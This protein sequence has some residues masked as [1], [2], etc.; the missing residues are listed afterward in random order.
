MD[1]S[2]LLLEVTMHDAS[3]PWKCGGRDAARPCTPSALSYHC[4]STPVL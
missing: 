2:R 4:T 1:L 3:L